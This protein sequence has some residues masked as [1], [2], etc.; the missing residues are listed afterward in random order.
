MA[1]LLGNRSRVRPPIFDWDIHSH[2]AQA[3]HLFRFSKGNRY[4]SSNRAATGLIFFSV[5]SLA[6][7]RIIFA[8]P[9][10]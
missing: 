8:L 5:K 1:R 3:G 7:S 10:A 6:I 9:S 2:Q 4:S